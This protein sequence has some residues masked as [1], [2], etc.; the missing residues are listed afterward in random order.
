[1]SKIFSSIAKALSA[2]HDDDTQA[3]ARHD[4]VV[5]EHTT[6]H[7]TEEVTPV[8]ERDVDQAIVHQTVEQHREHE[9]RTEHAEKQLGT[10]EHET[11]DASEH[12]PAGHLGDVGHESTHSA[13][14][15]E[16][17]HKEPI[18][19][20]TVHTHHVE[21]VQ[22]VI[23]KDID[24]TVVTHVTQPVHEHHIASPVVDDHVEVRQ[25]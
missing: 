5:Q 9:A 20:E 16:T 3:T 7:Q 17:V 18:I 25:V 13:G 19:H 6:H 1:M 10:I 11:R 22:P 8:I 15:H 14:A 21:E 24:E 2:D 4:A 12:V 23:Q